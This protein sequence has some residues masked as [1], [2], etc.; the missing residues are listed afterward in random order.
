MC[1]CARGVQEKTM[2]RDDR[3]QWVAS[4]AV[5]AEG[6]LQVCVL[7]MRRLPGA[8]LLQLASMHEPLLDRVNHGSS[9]NKAGEYGGKAPRQDE[10][11]GPLASRLDFDESLAK[12]SALS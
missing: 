4:L 9:S 1:V 2:N 5:G 3:R 12:H 10:L 8:L 6:L 11:Q 7:G